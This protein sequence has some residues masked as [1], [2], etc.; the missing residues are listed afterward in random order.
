MSGPRAEAAGRVPARP[1]TVRMRASRRSSAMPLTIELPADLLA[2]LRHRAGVHGRTVEEETA[3]VLA[4]ACPPGH[5]PLP[6][7]WDAE[8]DPHLTSAFRAACRASG[9]LPAES[10]VD[11]LR[12]VVP[13]DP[14]D[15]DLEAFNREWAAHEAEVAR[16]EREDAERDAALDAEI[17]AKTTADAA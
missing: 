9:G 17:E 12:R 2:N 4:V 14:K 8:H 15:F 16:G 11:Y 1:V 13:N 7:G 6:D 10:L 3:A 5:G